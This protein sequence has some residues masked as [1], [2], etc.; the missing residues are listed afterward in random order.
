MAKN[1]TTRQA[2]KPAVCVYKIR[3]R[4]DGLYSKGGSEP[5]FAVNGKAWTNI[6]HVRNHI[7]L[8]RDGLAAKP[9][10]DARLRSFYLDCDIVTFVVSTTESAVEPVVA[11][12]DGGEIA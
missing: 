11:Y 2:S 6:G 12:I 8:V 1:P 5:R 9:K 3:R 4:S 10:N 7:T